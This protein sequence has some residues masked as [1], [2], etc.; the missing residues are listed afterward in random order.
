M[1]RSAFLFTVI[2][3]LTA[4]TQL[5]FADGSQG[6]APKKELTLEE[7]LKHLGLIIPE[8]V[9]RR[10]EEL[11]QQPS[12]VLLN[13]DIRF[14]WRERGGVTPVK[15][16]GE[17]GSCWDFGATGAIESAVLIAD[18]VEWDLSEQQIMD[19]NSARQGCDGG[20]SSTVYGHV[21]NYGEVQE[22]CY[23]YRA[24]SPMPCE[25]DT[26][27]VMV[28][29]DSYRQIQNSVSA[30]KN[31]L[32][33]RPVSSC[34]Y[35]YPDFHWNCYENWSGVVNHLVLIVGWDDT[36]CTDGAWIIKNSWGAGWGDHGFFHLPY[37]SSGI[38]LY[39]EQPTYVSHLPQLTYQPEAMTFNLP[40]GGEASQTLTLG[41]TGD[42]DLHYRIRLFRPGFQDEFGYYWFDSDNPNGPEY[43]WI[44]LNGV[45]Q[46]VDFGGNPDNANSGPIDLGFDF[47][48][49]GNTFNTIC[50]CSNG[51][52][53]FTDG[54]SVNSYNMPI[55]A[56]Y[57]P[58]D[59]LAPFWTDLDPGA[60]GDVYYY[61]N[62]AD[63]AIISWEE[64]YDSWEEGRFTFQ[65]VLVAP[66]TIVYQYESMGPG[67]R[68]DRATI[69][70]E[71][72]SG[73]VGLQVSRNEIYTYGQKA[74]QFYLGDPPGA[75]D[76]LSSSNDHGTIWE[77]GS[78]DIT[79]SCAA[80][81]HPDGKYWGIINLYTNDPDSIHVDIPVV[82]NV[83]VTSVGGVETVALS[84][85]LKQN[86]PNPFNP[87]TEIRYN[88]PERANVR[89]E[90]YNLSGQ[91]IETLVNEPQ[92][93]GVHWVTWDASTYSSGVY[94]YKLIAGDRVSAKRMTLLR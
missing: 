19:C 76:W 62:N 70:M 78:W 91:R 33:D 13:P 42:G 90:I 9:K 12:P 26:C 28:T 92:E 67:G 66:D 35:V 94:F 86:Y 89:L 18:T 54:T 47:D 88:L 29:I 30:I 75:F 44:D 46:V 51:W 87:T 7:R 93:P 77:G 65:I 34:Y 56:T 74:V 43:A 1:R 3:A 41:N 24:R 80:G 17:C 20:W 31:A 40:S 69:G 48:F 15:D 84:H 59:L 60:G 5:A 39:T 2:F 63:S 64:V 73:T 10:F 49:Y 83:G 55:P 57:A 25:Q 36:L 72:G 21:M 71:N 27:V 32:L 79:I 81:D 4:F 58:N 50:I 68:I 45:G 52:A 8:D 23:P 22:E 82:M 16:Q 11:D 53:S 14:D 85:S 61:T 6:T 38:G 37:G